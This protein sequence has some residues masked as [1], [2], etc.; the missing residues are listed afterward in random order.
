M[1]TSMAGT[2]IQD[3][4][5]NRAATDYLV[6]LLSIALSFVARGTVA[7]RSSIGIIICPAAF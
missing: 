4:D 5:I 2:P 6:Y 1:S 3:G 7:T